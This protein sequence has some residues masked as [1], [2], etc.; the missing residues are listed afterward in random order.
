MRREQN[1][2]GV[3]NTAGKSKHIPLVHAKNIALVFK[4]Q[5][6]NAANRHKGCHKNI[7]AGP[8][9]KKWPRKKRN[10]NNVDRSKKGILPCRSELAADSLQKISHEQKEAQKHSAHKGLFCKPKKPLM[11]QKAKAESRNRKPKG[12]HPDRPNVVK[13]VLYHN[14]CKSPNG[15]AKHKPHAAKS[16]QTL[17]CHAILLP[18]K[19]PLYNRFLINH[20][21]KTAYNSWLKIPASSAGMTIFFTRQPSIAGL[22]PPMTVR[23]FYT[24]KPSP[25]WKGG[26]AGHR[27]EVRRL[28]R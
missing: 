6:T 25:D 21:F 23:F 19:Q 13:A 27:N 3:K 8:L 12:N 14:K 18:K 20:P 26:G 15:S 17:F 28:E 5:K 7:P 22:S 4:S 10:Q 2:Q 1:M 9:P 11:Q 16:T 24:I